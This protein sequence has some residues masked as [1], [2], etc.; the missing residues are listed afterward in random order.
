MA[1]HRILDDLYQ[2]TFSLIAIHSYLEDYHLAYFLNQTL[3]S[4]LKKASY[5]IDFDNEISYNVF[6]WDDVYQ[7]TLWNLITN[8]ATA[9]VPAMQ[10]E[11]LFDGEES[12]ATHYLIPEL[13]NVDYFLKI[14]NGA[15]FTELENTVKA[16]HEIPKITTAYAVQADKLKSKNNLIF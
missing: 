3:K 2:P 16:I 9:Q 15:V 10:I 6:E 13:K 14:D 5:T 4:Q 7:D 12:T 8:T 1:V 11:N